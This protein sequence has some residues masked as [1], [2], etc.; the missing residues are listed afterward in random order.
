MV[1]RTVA[2]IR[3]VRVTNVPTCLGPWGRTSAI[4]SR[5]AR[6]APPASRLVALTGCRRPGRGL[7]GS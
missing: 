5:L 2:R 1:I 3:A 6:S 4:P 7:P